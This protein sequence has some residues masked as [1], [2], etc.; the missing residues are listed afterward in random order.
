MSQTI[1]KSEVLMKQL[2]AL[3][4]IPDK[5]QKLVLTL[6]VGEVATVSF[7]CLVTEHKASE[8]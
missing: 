6:E 1:I 8:Q 2:R 5:V 4:D 7:Q 3:I